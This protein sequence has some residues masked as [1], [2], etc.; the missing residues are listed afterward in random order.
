MHFSHISIGGGITGLE[1]IIAAFER[2][3]KELKAGKFKKKK[4]NFAV[5]EK[6]IENIPGGV[7]YGFE[8]SKYGY[9]NNPLR[10]SPKKFVKWVFQKESKKKIISYLNKFGGYTGKNW[11]N[12]N[13]KVLFSSNLKKLNEL[14]IPRAILNVW[15]EER[16]IFL[17]SEI[18]KIN[19]SSSNIFGL[20]FYKGE[21]VNIKK[22]KKEFNKLIF[23][24][25]FCEKL[26]YNLTKNPLKKLL[27]KNTNN[28]ENFIYSKTQCIGLGLP[29][30]K[31]LATLKAQMNKNY[32]WDFYTQGSTKTI[33]QKIFKTSKTKKKLKI[34][35]I[36][37]KAGLL[38]SL[39]ELKEVISKKR[40]NVEL[41]CSSKNLESIQ[42][43]KLTLDK[44]KY[45][46]SK[47]CWHEIKKIKKA[48]QIYSLILNEF[49]FAI[50]LGYKKYDA[51]TEILKKN[52][53]NKCI[54]N[55]N[56]I[57]KKKYNDIYH[58]K[59]RVITRFT[60]PET[61]KARENLL[62]Q[63]ILKTKKEVVSKVDYSSGKLTVLSKSLE[64][65]NKKSSY[66]LVINVSGPLNVEKIK[67]EIALV[68][69]LK[70]QGAKVKSGGFVVDSNFQLIG[71]KNVYTVGIL[72]RGFNPE[73]KTILKAILENSTIA[74][75]SIAKTLLCI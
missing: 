41:I 38:E 36:G 11:I 59:I 33:I 46:L 74:G 66:D 72:A 50:T 13:K 29:P 26:N 47:K 42:D 51:W 30:P 31:Q 22:D 27:F 1:T 49:N 5:V 23:K 2:V 61:I 14:Y 4:I 57:Q 15:M 64:K 28:K 62:G 40:F 73:R 56:L 12:Q 32:I 21:V 53:L 19:Q 3:K 7:A 60:Y 34:Y 6:K 37:Y 20:E 43:A 16:L 35:F 69:S 9:F 10:L 44:K 25:G 58:N 52:I 48:K 67:N 54:N 17:I 65:K 75:Q 63:N 68:K 8:S 70:T 45:I 71:I 55:L 39:P 24:D 18:K